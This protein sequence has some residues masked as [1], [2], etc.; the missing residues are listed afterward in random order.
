MEKARAQ[1][2]QKEIIQCALC[3]NQWRSDPFVDIPWESLS[4]N[5]LDLNNTLIW[6]KMVNEG[7]ISGNQMSPHKVP[8]LGGGALL[9]IARINGTI[10]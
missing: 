9:S 7:N 8:S 6:K 3:I 2:I 4:A 10:F 1:K 5:G